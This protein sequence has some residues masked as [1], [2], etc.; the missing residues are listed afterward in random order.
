[1]DNTEKRRRPSQ[2]RKA[3]RELMISMGGVKYTTALREFERL[4]A[5]STKEKK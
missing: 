5:E 2:E 4:K 1:M 3:I